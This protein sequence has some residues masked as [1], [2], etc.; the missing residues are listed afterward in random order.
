MLSRDLA[1]RCPR[2]NTY[3]KPGL[4]TF[5]SL[6]IEP[7][8][9]DLFG[10]SWLHLHTQ[11]HAMLVERVTEWHPHHSAFIL[12]FLVNADL[13][14]LY[15]TPKN[16]KSARN[17]AAPQR[18][19]ASRMTTESNSA[20]PR[21]VS[22]HHGR[23]NAAR[24]V[25][26][27][28]YDGRRGPLLRQMQS[29]AEAY[30]E[31]ANADVDAHKGNT[32]AVALPS[33]CKLQRFVVS[34]RHGA[35]ASNESLD[36]VAVPTAT[37]RID[38]S[39]E[40]P[41]SSFVRIAGFAP[42]FRLAGGINLPKIVTCLGTDGRERRQLVKGKDD[43]RQDAV[44]QQVFAAANRLLSKRGS[45]QIPGA[46]TS[47]S[48]NSD[49]SQNCSWMDIDG[50]LRIH[51]YKVIPMA[52]RTGVIEWCENTVPLGEWLAADRSGAHQRY[53]PRDMPPGQARQKLAAVRDRPPER[54][55]VVFDEICEKLSPVLAY[56][57]LEN[58]RDPQSWCRARYA[59]TR[60]LAASSLVGYLV[61]LG[62]RHPQNLLLHRSSGELI[63]IDLGVAFDQGRLLP[64]PEAVPFRLTRDL[65]HALGPLGL[66][67]AFIPA[68]E[69]VLTELRN[70][71]DVILTLLQVLLHDPLYS[72]SM[73]PTQLCALEARR[74]EFA[75][76]PMQS[77]AA[78][79]RSVLTDQTNLPGDLGRQ[80]LSLVVSVADLSGRSVMDTTTEN[81]VARVPFATAGGREPLNQL[82]ERVLLN[83]RGKLEGRVTGN[84][85]ASS[86]E[87]RKCGGLD[88]LD[89]SGHVSLLV[90]SATDR[91]NLSRMY[92]GWQA[93][94]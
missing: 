89:V 54:R 74:A 58:F 29:L 61:G 6:A 73:T 78:A 22:E 82:A 19:R 27:R 25:L 5:L 31:W 48:P 92:F 64:T 57:Y 51:T 55:R 70:A 18:S 34:T 15:V 79:N 85:A 88:Q 56:F 9:F 72:W 13:D 1:S 62:D 52:Q 75:S 4:I 69:I 83:V 40:Y 24:R 59:Y 53:R 30:V 84:L 43:P 87:H 65:V 12:L 10:P 2:T 86:S 71:S 39:G 20:P 45:H 63:H 49:S 7:Y 94:L 35:S 41:P 21:P 14:E 68:A 26:N 17:F 91:S 93:Y 81:A 76:R 16:D 8:R 77:N 23:A 42:K 80:T 90:R 33:N 32:D 3:H 60:S 46:R 47:Y 36:L 28:L 37:L 67:G 38:R 11:E 44:M 66:E 50:G